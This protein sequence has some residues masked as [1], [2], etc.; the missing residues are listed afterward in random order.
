[1][2]SN[3]F[4][5]VFDANDDDSHYMQFAPVVG[6]LA[7]ERQKNLDILGKLTKNKPVLNVDK[8]VNTQIVSEQKL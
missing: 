5:C 2:E 3:H 4:L 8:A 1:M 7:A 6:D